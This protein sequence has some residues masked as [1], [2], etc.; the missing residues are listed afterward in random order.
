MF[1]KGFLVELGYVLVLDTNLFE[2]DYYQV[3]CRRSAGLE[4][5]QLIKTGGEVVIDVVRRLITWI[6]GLNLD[7]NIALRR[8]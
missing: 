8:Y 3:L 5:S 7:P 6:I 4:L 2:D 1:V